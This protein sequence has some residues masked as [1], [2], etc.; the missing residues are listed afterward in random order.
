MSGPWVLN[1]EGFPVVWCQC[2]PGWLLQ[3]ARVAAGSILG[4]TIHLHSNL[5]MLQVPQWSGASC[6]SLASP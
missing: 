1:I 5:G 3:L 6:I 2:C 4:L